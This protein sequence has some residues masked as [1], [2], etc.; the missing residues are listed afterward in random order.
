MQK[1]GVQIRPLAD[2]D[3]TRFASARISFKIHFARIDIVM[4]H[5]IFGQRNR[6]ICA[7]LAPIVKL[8]RDDDHFAIV[9]PR[10]NAEIFL[11]NVYTDA[12]KI[13]IP[14]RK[15]SRYVVLIRWLQSALILVVTAQSAGVLKP[16][17]E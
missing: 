5:K 10:G 11:Q 4:L 1:C 8:W 2:Y 16:P 12:L 13:N 3:G 14:R 9:I 15:A 6:L 17:H 7:H